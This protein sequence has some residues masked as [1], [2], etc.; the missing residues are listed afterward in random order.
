[1]QNIPIEDRISSPGGP[2]D[3]QT[4]KGILRNEG[5]SKGI[6][7]DVSEEKKQGR[8]V[9]V[10]P[11]KHYWCS[12]DS[13]GKQKWF[14]ELT[15]GRVVSDKDENYFFWLKKHTDRRSDAKGYTTPVER[16][17]D[18]FQTPRPKDYVRSGNSFENPLAFRDRRIDFQN[19]QGANGAAPLRRNMLS[20]G[21]LRRKSVYGSLTEYPRRIEEPSVPENDGDK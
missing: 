5:I 3:F 9:V 8:A 21:G 2:K 19:S 12:F 15:N 20:F 10:Y 1:M 17:K 4:P 6:P 7:I 14:I 11:K 16:K 18:H 13:E